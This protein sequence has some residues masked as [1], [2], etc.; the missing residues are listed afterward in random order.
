MSRQPIE[1]HRPI[2]AFD[3][4]GTL[5]TKDSFKAFLRWKVGP[6]RYVAGWARLA[7]EVVAYLL[8]R[9][10][11]R[12]KAAAA[13]IYLGRASREEIESWARAFAESHAR[14]LL[15]PDALKVWR[16]WR[17]HNARLTIVT[18]SPEELIA[19]FARGLGAELLLGS[20]LAYDESGR[21][22]GRLEGA[23]CR[24]AE[25]VRRLREAYGEDMRLEAAY[26]DTD[27]DTAMLAA[28]EEPGYR[29]FSGRPGGLEG[30]RRKLKRPRPI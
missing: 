4:D 6:A 8:R 1:A 17:E 9:D 11:G 29:V 20:R 12:L 25:K 16:Y 19:P 7:P 2:V 27:G 24:G 5:T 13:R 3:F 18:A 21:F 26:G 15:R 23:N 10:R 22:T 30:E 14:R 28:A